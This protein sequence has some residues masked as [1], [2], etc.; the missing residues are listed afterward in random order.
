VTGRRYNRELAALGERAIGLLTM[1]EAAVA[2]PGRRSVRHVRLL[3]DAGELE[4]V[5]LGRLDRITPESV[6]AYKKR[7]IAGAEAARDAM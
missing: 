1:G 5:R 2:L 7:L 3:A 4:R 6:A